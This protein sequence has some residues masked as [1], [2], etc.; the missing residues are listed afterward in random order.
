[1]YAFTCVLNVS[2]PLIALL[3]SLKL[4]PDLMQ[5]SFVKVWKVYHLNGAGTLKPKTEDD[6]KVLQSESGETLG[7]VQNDQ[8]D[9]NKQSQLTLSFIC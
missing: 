5:W 3:Q 8:D 2:F 7:K 6:V 1:M 9:K 4:N